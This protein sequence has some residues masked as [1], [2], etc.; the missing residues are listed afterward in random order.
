M[1]DIGATVAQVRAEKG[2]TQ[3][4]LATLAKTSQS[5]ISQIEKGERT[6]SFATIRQLATALEVS[7]AD[8]LGVVPDKLGDEDVVHFRKRK[9]LSEHSKIALDEYLTF[10]L[11]KE[12]KKG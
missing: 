12:P 8:L 1:S 5:A 4:Q 11:A 10:L 9:H 7:V 2:L 3:E 6:P